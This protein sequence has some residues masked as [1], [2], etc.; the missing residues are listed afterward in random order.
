ML[1]EQEQLIQKALDIMRAVNADDETRILFQQREESRI[2]YYARLSGAREEGIKAGR[3][4]VIA[5][6]RC[7]ML[8]NRMDDLERAMSDKDFRDKLLAEYQ[9]V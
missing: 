5:L 2:D 3:Q 7:L 9:I 1:E 4:M 8:D 6:I